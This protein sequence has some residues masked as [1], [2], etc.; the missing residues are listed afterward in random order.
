[1]HD[2]TFKRWLAV[3][4]ASVTVL[5]AVAT[6]WQ[7]QASN[8]AD[9]YTRRSQEAAIRAT[10]EQSRG[11]E[12]VS[13][14]RYSVLA[15]GDELYTYAV[16]NGSSNGNEVGAAYLKARES[17]APLS[18]LL[19]PSYT[20]FDANG[21]RNQT[22]FGLYEAETYVVNARLYDE[23][24]SAYAQTS[25][26]WNAKDDTYVAVIAIFAV[27]LFLF[28]LASTL[29]GILRAF[30]V[31][32]GMGIGTVALAWMLLTYLRPVH[33]IPD[34]ALRQVAEGAGYAAQANEY[35]APNATE[36]FK[37]YN[38][39]WQKAI[40]AYGEALA[41]DPTYANAYNLRGIARLLIQPI[42]AKEAVEDFQ[43]AIANGKENYGTYW[44]LGAAQYYNG[45]FDKVAA[46][47]RRALELNPRACGP[48]FNIG[49]AALAQD[50][51]DDA[52]RLYEEAI[53]LCGEIYDDARIHNS[54]PPVSL[55]THMQSA[56][57]ELDKLL[58]VLAKRHCYPDRNLPPLDSL[59]N[60][61]P[62]IERAE[63]LRRRLK[64][65]LTA[66]EFQ[67]TT[68]VD[69]TGAHFEPV[70]FAYYMVDP[71]QTDR[72]LNYAEKDVFP[73]SV[74]VPDIDALS[75]YTGMNSDRFVVWKVFRDGYEELGLR[76]ADKWNLPD[77][78]PVVKKVNSWYVLPPG[79]YDLEIYVD[80]ELVSDGSFEISTEP[81]LT[82]PLPSDAQPKAPVSVGKLLYADDF[83][84]NNANWWTGSG[85]VQQEGDVDQNLT[86]V[87]HA[88]DRSFSSSCTPCGPYSDFYLEVDTRY[89][90][91]PKDYGYGIIYRGEV[92]LNTFYTFLISSD[93]YYR[94]SYWKDGWTHLID[95]TQSDV[96]NQGGDNT[97]GVWCR[98]A[99]CDFYINGQ[100]VNS[101]DDQ[102]LSG[103]FIGVRVDS[104]DV[105]ASFDNVRLWSVE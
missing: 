43:Q 38:E 37:H 21:L 5:I 92:D 13:F 41:L 98:A 36:Y 34:A 96:I 26:E 91:G 59:S 62:V 46:S 80:G 53:A 9:L 55:W 86:I 4:I 49:L 70:Q 3:L 69:P 39:Y 94:V 7:T 103:Q 87:T 74:N 6:L 75:S 50:K 54:S 71:R 104:T 45:E 29:G 68:R 25:G 56:V 61:A 66:L 10:G 19:S 20:Q 33:E 30:F 18:P 12:R 99:H 78:G 17:L 47:S 81:V 57:D 1:M 89:V 44:N 79:Q 67:G 40:D 65:A 31:V 48:Y 95:W 90:S 27:S 101:K 42:Q 2:E 52:T 102:T 22:D 105:Q 97:L 8:R 76:W 23:Q 93:G 88:A 84:N 100:R 15:F 28:A 51:V 82:D 32:V 35:V 83:D 64:E 16:R 11:Q 77:E 60:P 72:F 63:A 73:Y 58:C 14:D 24:R 85:V